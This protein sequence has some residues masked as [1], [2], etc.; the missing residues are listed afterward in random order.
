MK[1]KLIAIETRRYSE[2]LRRVFESYKDADFAKIDDV[3]YPASKFSDI[4]I[5][6]CENAKILNTKNFVLVKDKRELFGFH[7]HPEQMWGAESEIAF[8]KQLATEKI[9]RFKE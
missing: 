5:T 4:I 8:I 9:L 1:P 7:D 3:E 2:F 6:W